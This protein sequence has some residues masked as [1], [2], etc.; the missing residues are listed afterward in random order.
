MAGLD[1]SATWTQLT[2]EQ[3]YEL[4][5]DQR[6]RELPA[7]KVGTTEEVLDALR[8]TRLSEWHSRRDALPVR[9][10]NA[11]AA[12]A[13]LLEPKAQEVSLTSATIKTEDD[14]KG[15]LADTEQRIRE[16]LKQG[17]VIV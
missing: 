12:A 4:L 1:Q 2:P 9:F 15:W 11:V 14:L 7:I 16:Q 13:K 3:K 10:G 5:G 17:P 8:G 6:I